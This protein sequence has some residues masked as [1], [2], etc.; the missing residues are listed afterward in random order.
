MATIEQLIEKLD[1]LNSRMSYKV[2]QGRKYRKIV[3]VHEDGRVASVHCFIDADDNIYKPAG[4]AAPA[5]GV[6]ATL[7]TLNL[8]KVDHFGG[9]LYR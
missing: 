4:W 2:T 8:D 3:D 1:K 6:R 5:K 7:A 9:W